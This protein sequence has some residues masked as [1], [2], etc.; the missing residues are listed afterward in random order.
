MTVPAALKYLFFKA[1]E[2]TVINDS[3]LKRKLKNKGEILC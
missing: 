3:L 1:V 2:I